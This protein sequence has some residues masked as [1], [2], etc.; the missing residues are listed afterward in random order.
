MNS[1]GITVLVENTAQDHGLYGEHGLSFWIESGAKRI[2]FDTGQTDIVWHNAHRLNIDKHSYRR[3]S[4]G[5]RWR[6]TY[7]RYDSSFTEI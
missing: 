1:L 2:L 3:D 7:T 4:S 6:G 5:Y